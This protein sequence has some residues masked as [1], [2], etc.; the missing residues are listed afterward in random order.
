[1]VMITV[2]MSPYIATIL[3]KILSLTD[4]F[5]LATMMLSTLILNIFHTDLGYTGYIMGAYLTTEYVDYINPIYVMLTSLYGFVQLFIPT[6]ILLG[7]GLTSLNVKY[8]DWL[9]FIFKFLIGMFICLLVVFILM[10]LI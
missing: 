7:V 9:K 4:G 8:K 1:M 2:Y 6:S 10:T 5:N 3:N